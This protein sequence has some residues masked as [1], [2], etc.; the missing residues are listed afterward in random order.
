MSTSNSVKSKKNESSK[1]ARAETRLLDKEYLKTPNP[2]QGPIPI[3]SSLVKNTPHGEK[4]AQW[5]CKQEKKLTIV[6]KMIAQKLAQGAIEPIIKEVV[7][8][9]KKENQYFGK[10]FRMKTDEND[11]MVKGSFQWLNIE[12]N[13]LVQVEGFSELEN[14][15]YL[16]YRL[17]SG[18][19]VIGTREYESED[20]LC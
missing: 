14:K 4:Q 3:S 9:S 10:L 6:E 18:E 5:S 16:E 20:D 2:C 11:K 19:P 13:D 8:I 15:R 7:G 12:L 17:L 1:L